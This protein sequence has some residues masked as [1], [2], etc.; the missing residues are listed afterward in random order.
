MANVSCFCRG[1]V[2]PVGGA[3]FLRLH[4]GVCEAWGWG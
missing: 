2:S 4:R 3:L 1:G